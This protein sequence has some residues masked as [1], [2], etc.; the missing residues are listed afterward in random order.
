MI[1]ETDIPVYTIVVPDND[2]SKK[3]FQVSKQSFEQRGYSVIEWRATT[4]QTLGYYPEL[5]YVPKQSS[6]SF[7]KPFTATE[8]AVW[9]S[10]YSLW[11]HCVELN[12]PIIVA[13]HDAVLQGDLVKYQ[14]PFCA[15]G[16][17]PEGKMWTAVCYYIEPKAAL[18][19]ATHACTKDIDLNVD[20]FIGEQAIETWYHIKD[21]Q[22]SL[23]WSKYFTVL[24]NKQPDWGNTIQHET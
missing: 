10:H 14:T 17:D 15:Y 12:T 3:Y 20:G 13:E 4:P 11:L 7:L 24:H 19:M 8:K 21:N 16:T 18:Y 5:T 23:L 1:I 6:G 22:F 9:A 2:V